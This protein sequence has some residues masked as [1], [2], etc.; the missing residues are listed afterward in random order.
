MKKSYTV[1]TMVDNDMNSID[2]DGQWWTII[3]TEQTVMDKN[4]Y[5][6]D[7]YG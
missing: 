2:S 4:I 6:T 3:Y 5:S 7:S 1:E